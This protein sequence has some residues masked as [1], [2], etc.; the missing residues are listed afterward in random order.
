MSCLNL[1]IYP[2]TIY[3]P[4][5]APVCLSHC[6]CLPV[7]LY[8]HSRYT[9]V[10]VFCL[11]HMSL[12]RLAFCP[13]IQLFVLPVWRSSNNWSSSCVAD[14][15]TWPNSATRASASLLWHRR[16]I[17]SCSPK[18]EPISWLPNMTTCSVRLLIG[19]NRARNVSGVEL[20]SPVYF[21]LY[22]NLQVARRD[23]IIV[24]VTSFVLK[25]S[26]QSDYVEFLFCIDHIDQNCLGST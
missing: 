18:C 13:S 2:L 15:S 23:S 19:H 16:T 25:C 7:P 20:V 17:T 4:I 21:S 1:S 24:G 10:R 22:S 9:V 12:S 5:H 11:S 26:W 3:S 6:V 8:I 14:V